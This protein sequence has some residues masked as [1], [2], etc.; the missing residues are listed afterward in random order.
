MMGAKVGAEG[1]QRSGASPN[2]LPSRR[3]RSE[4]HLILLRLYLGRQ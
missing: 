3:E 1:M 4:T 2:G